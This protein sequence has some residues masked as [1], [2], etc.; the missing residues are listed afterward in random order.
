MKT[1]LK[2]GF[3]VLLLLNSLYA[4][5]VDEKRDRAHS[6]RKVVDS[7]GKL[8]TKDISIVDSFK[9]MFIDGK[10][11]GQIKSIYGTY[12]QKERGVEDSYATAL[13]G[14]LKYELAEFNGFNAGAAVYTSHD[15]NFATGAGTKHNNELSSSS[16]EYTQMAEVYIN[17]NYKDLNIRVGRQSL[18]TP[19]ADSDDIRMIQNS[20]NAYILTYNYAGIDFMIG[21]LKSWQGYD[22]DLDTPWST[23]G[24]DGTNLIGASYSDGLE[25]NLWYYNITQNMNAL[26]LDTGFEYAF[27]KEYQFHTMVQYLHESELNSSGFAADIYGA[28]LEIVAYDI[29]FNIAFNKSNKQ[30]GK[31]TFSGNGGG[32]MFTSMDTSIIDDLANDRDVLAIVAG[33]VY[34]IND[35]NLLY[36]YGDFNGDENSAGQ[37]E[38]KVEHDFSIEYNVNDEFLVSAVYATVEDKQHKLKTQYDWNRVQV[39]VNYNF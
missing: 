22:A 39:M 6:V 36:A 13:G 3:I 1:I 34:S 7:I 15:I 17:Y 23:T 18:E 29:G 12:N 14:I 30:K 33:I 24:K 20:F 32:T 19:L 26:Y 5:S 21:H 9:H 38:H 10:L 2:I 4:E 31:Q 35:F 37:K 25:F 28:L 11:S 8:E 16:G 27:S